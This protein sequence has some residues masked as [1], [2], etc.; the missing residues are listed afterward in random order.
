M[1]VQT[2]TREIYQQT[3]EIKDP[4]LVSGIE[5]SEHVFEKGLDSSG[6]LLI[7]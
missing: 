2:C 3:L 6:V 5:N 4:R 7:A 1:I